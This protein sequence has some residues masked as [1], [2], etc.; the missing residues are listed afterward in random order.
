MSEIDC[1]IIL[2]SFMDDIFSF[3]TDILNDSMSNY[4][5]QEVVQKLIQTIIKYF[6]KNIINESVAK[7][8]KIITN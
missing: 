7:C 8:Q 1:L 4:K 6:D 5:L 2:I 3:I